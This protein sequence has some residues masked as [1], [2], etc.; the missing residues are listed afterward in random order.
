MALETTMSFVLM[1]GI[2]AAFFVWHSI[3][4]KLP[5]TEAVPRERYRWPVW[6]WYA[7]VVIS[8][9]GVAFAANFY[10]NQQIPRDLHA[11][12]LEPAWSYDARQPIND[13]DPYGVIEDSDIQRV[14]GKEQSQAPT[15]AP[16]SAP[17]PMETS[18]AWANPGEG[19]VPAWANPGT[20]DA[21][22]VA[23]ATG[24]SPA[25]AATPANPDA[26]PGW[27]EPVASPQPYGSPTPTPSGGPTPSAT[28]S[29]TGSPSPR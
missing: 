16:T 3:T 13:P 23:P 14:S 5:F 25:W 6:N 4:R 8:G 1:A 27:G 10:W 29:P 11:N 12:E 7:L 28:P 20:G 21:P 19:D 18:P 9:F 26:T 15:A 24:D 22:A 2:L 17:T